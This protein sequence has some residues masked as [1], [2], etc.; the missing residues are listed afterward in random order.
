MHKKITLS[1]MLTMVA[2][3]SLAQAL[4]YSPAKPKEGDKVSFTYNI[5][6]TPLASAKNPEFAFMA[7]NFLDNKNSV[8]EVKAA[9]KGTVFTGSFTV[10]SGAHFL[11]FRAFEDELK[12]D[13]NKKGYLI[14]IHDNAGNTVAG[15]AYSKGQ[16]LANGFGEFFLGMESS[17]DKAM[18]AISQ[19]WNNSPALRTKMMNM[20]FSMLTRTKKKEAEP[21]IIK[22]LEALEAAG[23]LTEADYLALAN[24]YGRIRKAD[25]ATALTALMKEKFPAGNWKKSEERAEI[26]KI[27][28]FEKRFEAIGTFIKNNPPKDELESNINKSMYNALVR[29]YTNK[30]KI[31][32]SLLEKYTEKLGSDGRASV[33]NNLA[34]DWASKKDTLITEAAALSKTATTWAK[35]EIQ[36]PTTKKSDF[37][38]NNEFKKQIESQYAMYANTYAYILNK[39]KNS[40][41]A[42][43]YAEDGCKITN[44]KQ[45]E[46]NNLYAQIAEQLKTPQD[47]VSILSPM[48]EQGNAGNEVKEVLKRALVKTTGTEEKAEAQF[49]RL[50][51]VSREKERQALA[52]KMI[53]EDAPQF[54][55]KNLEGAEVS[56]ASLKG[57]VVIADFWATWC[58]P[59]IASFPG[60]QKAVTKYKNNS[61]VAFV[62]IDTWERQPTEEQRVKEVTDFITKNKYSFNVLYDEKVGETDYNVVS[63]F[64]ITGIP[65]KFI[66]DQDGKVRFK[67][68]GFSG[69][70]DK[71]VDEVSAMIDMI[72]SK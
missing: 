2:L 51:N 32:M 17:T 33:Y 26:A 52:K 64:K 50:A 28:D 68:V 46:Y 19:E 69:N 41:A 5:A 1:A 38:T 42:F 14:D 7:I 11:A 8:I 25:K 44:W 47:L 61:N 10:P 30:G 27:T 72:I 43:T 23:N 3:V 48:L 71:V 58:G 63:K 4:T 54:K 53:N 9:K 59:C 57:K 55:L 35:A 12:D 6:N 22:E 24:N 15:N 56:L 18:E 65:T 36:K 70:D 62:F 45:A 31:E 40:T 13:N 67:S 29:A 39:Q 60:M 49:T 66:I 37:S 21:I 20:Y 16:I 34:W